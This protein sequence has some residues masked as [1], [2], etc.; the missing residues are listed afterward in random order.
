M[1]PLL[2]LLPLLFSST[3]LTLVLAGCEKVEAAPPMSLE[4]FCGDANKPPAT[5]DGRGKRRQIEGY[6]QM[7]T[8]FVMCDTTCL[9][10][11]STGPERKAPMVGAS[12]EVGGG[13]NRLE[14][15][16]KNFTSASIHLRTHDGRKVDLGKPVRLSGSRIG[17]DAKSCVITVDHVEQ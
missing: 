2:R 12:F 4:A 15:P 9:F 11:V 14:R 6:V 3:L 16:T 7:P 13:D 8:M 5:G 10:Q 1:R 17:S